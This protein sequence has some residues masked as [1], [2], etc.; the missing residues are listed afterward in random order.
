MDLPGGDGSPERDAE[1]SR[2]TDPEFAPA[3]VTAFSDGFPFL[4]ISEA[5]SFAGRPLRDI[6]LRV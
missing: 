3:H 4:L 2:P 1:V 5:R 6:P